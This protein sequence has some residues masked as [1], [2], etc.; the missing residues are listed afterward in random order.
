[1]KKLILLGV[2]LVAIIATLSVGT[3][4]YF[5]DTQV[6]TGNIFTAGTLDLG[7]SNSSGGSPTADTSATFSASTWAPG[8]TASGS[9]YINNAGS[10]AAGHVTVS[11]AKSAV[12][13]S[14]RPVVISGGPTVN[15]AG[16]TGAKGYCTVNASGAITNITIP[17]GDGGS[18]YT[19]GGAVTITDVGGSSGSSFAG[20]L[21]ASS[22]AVTSV[23]ITNGGSGYWQDT[24][25]VFDKNI[26]CTTATWHGVTQDGSGST[27]LIQGQTLAQ[28]VSAGTLNL[29]DT[30]YTLA[31]GAD[32]P[33]NLT[34]T[35]ASTAANGCQGCSVT[36]TVTVNLTQN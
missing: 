22:G 20:T 18:G 17:T 8:A 33:L 30:G 19:T 2:A 11:F 25:D 16:G 9:L 6:S 12:D 27:A 26:T 34:F 31:S 10:L 24:N 23:T 13:V 28:L 1:M 35:F 15:F 29:Y 21:V 36:L 32:Y 5:T 4:A 14:G 3:W 7:L